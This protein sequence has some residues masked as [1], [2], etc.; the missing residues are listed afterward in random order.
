MT[1]EA[2][3]V[4]AAVGRHVRRAIQDSGSNLRAAAE[5]AGLSYRSVLRY[6]SGERDMP[7]PV[8]LALVD[9][10]DADL[11]ELM[12]QLDAELRPDRPPDGPPPGD[13]TRHARANTA[14]S[15]DGPAVGAAMTTLQRAQMQLDQ[16]M[17][18][19]G[20]THLAARSIGPIEASELLAIAD[21]VQEIVQ[22]LRDT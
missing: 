6:I 22:E 11:T 17:R 5:R 7:V 9:A 15:A 16:R 1:D 4:N 21:V 13:R 12:H 18:E 20:V 3:A 8:L 19:L 2:H 14:G 10:S